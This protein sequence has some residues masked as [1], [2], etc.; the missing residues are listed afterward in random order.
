MELLRAIQ[1]RRYSNFVVL[2]VLAL[3]RPFQCG[4]SPIQGGYYAIASYGDSGECAGCE[5]RMQSS[6]ACRCDGG[7]TLQSSR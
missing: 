5:P 1:Y 7:H 4:H 6:E 2:V 3:A